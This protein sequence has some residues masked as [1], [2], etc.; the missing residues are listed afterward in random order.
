MHGRT[1]SSARERAHRTTTAYGRMEDQIIG[2][3][4]A[5]EPNAAERITRYNRETKR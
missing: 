5:A 2:S 3:I 1:D 4:A